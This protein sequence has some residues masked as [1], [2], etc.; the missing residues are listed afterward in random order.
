MLTSIG[1]AAAYWLY[2]FSEKDSEDPLEHLN[3]ALLRDP[4]VSFLERRAAE[5]AG[6]RHSDKYLDSAL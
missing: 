1:A 6:S 4:L 5:A 3:F 2:K